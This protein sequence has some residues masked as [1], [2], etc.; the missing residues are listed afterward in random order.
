MVQQ[1]G[2]VS[3]V[4]RP[5]WTGTDEQNLLLAEAVEAIASARAEEEKAWAKVQRA[6]RAGVPDLV[7]VKR[8]DVSRS[9]LNRK[10][11]P[12]SWET[13]DQA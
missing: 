12:R 8:A 11:G 9:T 1:S 3:P 2:N 10:L 6:R 4:I 5:S 13:V 7:V